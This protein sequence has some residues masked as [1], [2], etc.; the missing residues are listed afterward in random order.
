MNAT[1]VKSDTAPVAGVDRP[2]QVDLQQLSLKR[3]PHGQPVIRVPRRWLSRYVVP[4]GLL[5]AFAS[6]FA[7]SARNSFLPAHEVTITPVIVR[8]AEVQQAG[9]PLFQAA[10]WVEPRP[11]P[12]VVSSLAEGVVQEL[13][14]VEGQHVE[15]GKPIAKLFDTDAKLAAQQAEANLRLCNADVQNAESALA[16]AR[17]ALE[18]PNDLKASLADAESNLAETKLVLGNLPYMIEAAMARQRLAEESVVRKEHAGAAIA[19]R[20]LQEA[21][22]ELAAAES[23]LAELES[24]G[25]TLQAQ[26][27]ALARKCTALTEQLQLLTDQKRAVAGAE[28]ALAAAIARRDQAQLAAQKAA[29][30]LER[31]TI[32]APIS[33]RVLT[34]DAQPGKR[35]M[36]MDPASEQNSSTVISMYDP[37]LLQVRVDVRLE[38]VPHVQIGQPVQIQ[39]AALSQPIA[40]EV[41]WVTTRADI[42]KNT[43][44]VKVSIDDP[45][46]V[47]TPEM[48]AQVTFLAPPQPDASTATDQLPLRLLVPRPLVEQT[49]GGMSVWV[50]DT[51]AGTAQKH[52]VQLGRAGTDQLV[53]VTQGL[54]PTSKLIVTGRESLTVGARIRVVAEDQT[55]TR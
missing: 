12:I 43:L 20:V 48:L 7:W 21:K 15:R 32:V 25:P 49:G 4:I 26:Q 30:N 10:G 33:G 19:G 18:N 37:T 39:S 17:T 2:H 23:A 44:Q 6:L 5:A 1:S 42:Q 27:D 54:D 55:L 52:T 29:L 13:Y 50:A 51:A 31:M 45:P 28:A 8:R 11:T 47:I 16:A 40:G 14:A 38:D 34:L 22:A 35:L 9:A 36:G 53:E 3:S 24:R 46:Q 41:L